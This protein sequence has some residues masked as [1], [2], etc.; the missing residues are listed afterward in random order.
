MKFILYSYYR[1]ST[2]YRARIALHHKNIPFEYHAV[3]LLNDGGEQNKP[4][5]RHLNPMGGVPALVHG[6][7][8][9]GQSRAIM[10]YLDAVHPENPLFPKDP[11]W[12]AKVSQICDN[13]NCEIHPLSNL[14]VTQ[15][16]EKNLAQTEDQRTQWIHYWWAAGLKATEEVLKETAGT[17]AVGGDVTMADMFIAPLIFTA[18]RFKIPLH[19]YPTFCRVA[20]NALQLPAFKKAHPL[21]QPDTPPEML[22]QD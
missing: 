19:D 5:Y 15:Y 4:E 2:A 17:Y 7:R 9:L 14:R 22:I 1:S 20:D 8:V 10:E 16:L 3:H 13:V 18:H 11:Y 21:R 12:H 6:D